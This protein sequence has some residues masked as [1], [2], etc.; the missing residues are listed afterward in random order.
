LRRSYFPDINLWLSLNAADHVNTKPALEW[1][2]SIEDED[3][4]YFC[5]LTQLGLLRLLTTKS[6]MGVDTH[7]QRNA[8]MVYCKWRDEA[9][10]GFMNEPAG[11]DT[12]FRARSET[13]QASPKLWN[14]AYLAAFAEAA[15]L[16][17]VTF[18]H[19]LAEKASGAILL[20]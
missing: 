5:R 16:T 13:T 14:D 6:V 1:Y 2:Y 20:V 12:L 11:I 7:S 18:D 19:A 10:A 4:L 8:W 3:V 15:E 9:G 17:L